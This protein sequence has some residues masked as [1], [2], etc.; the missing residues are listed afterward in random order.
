[1]TT[2]ARQCTAIFLACAL[3]QAPGL[4][5]MFLRLHPEQAELAATYLAAVEQMRVW[6]EE[7]RSLDADDD[8]QPYNGVVVA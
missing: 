5:E 7:Q 3:A 1:M 4:A 8:G 6:C 2:D